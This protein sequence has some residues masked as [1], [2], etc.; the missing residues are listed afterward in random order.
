MW[1]RPL[2]RLEG[3]GLGCGSG[4]LHGDCVHVLGGR[5]FGLT[6]LPSEYDRRVPSWPGATDAA[7]T[8]GSFRVEPAWF[9]QRKERGGLGS[10]PG[11]ES[12]L[13]RM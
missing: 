4:C 7:A 12:R 8:L 11:L 1:P 5:W 10:R 3:E 13:S 2:G 6:R 9:G